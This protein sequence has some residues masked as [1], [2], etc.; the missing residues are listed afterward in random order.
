MNQVLN[1][2]KIFLLGMNIKNFIIFVVLLTNFKTFN[3]LKHTTMK[4]LFALLLAA[5]LVLATS[6]KDDEEANSI[7]TSEA[8]EV[9]AAAIAGNSG[10]AL[11]FIQTS[12]SVSAT[13]TDLRSASTDV[14]YDLGT[15]NA[16]ISGSIP[17]LT[18]GGPV[19]GSWNFN[20]TFS[21]ILAVTPIDLKTGTPV[22]VTSS[23]DY[24]GDVDAP[25]FSSSHSGNGKLVYTSLGRADG[26]TTIST[27]APGA[28]IVDS[29]WT[30]NGTFV[31]SATHN[32]KATSKQII[33]TTTVKFQDCEVKTDG[34]RKIKSGTAIVNVKGSVPKKGEFE[35]NGTVTFGSGSTGT[36]NIDGNVYTINI[37]SGEVQ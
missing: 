19:L 14:T 26:P 18:P 24:T 27:D 20:W 22:S 37:E 28:Y 9:T 31:R 35:Y 30:L 23:F 7:S 3:F 33:S 16:T 21:H 13:A 29:L 34:S 25:R 36:L 11:S 6:C 2:L 32:S 8:A 10:G 17:S 15:G 4:K 5:S 1:K 12:A